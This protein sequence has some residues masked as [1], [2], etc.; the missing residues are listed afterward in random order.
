MAIPTNAAE[1]EALLI[2]ESS[3]SG[4]PGLVVIN[5]DGS[6]LNVS[7]SNIWQYH[8][9]SSSTLTDTTV[10][11]APAA[12]IST[13]ITDISIST[14]AATALNFFLEEGSTKIFGPIYLEAVAGRGFT[15]T[16]STPLKVTAATAVT[17]TTSAA[18]AHSID[19][20]GFTA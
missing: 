8:E 4:Q 14:G 11:A 19:I 12:G 16:F 13:Y 10:K 20:Q 9:D 17:I 5:P 2:K 6:G 7:L 1:K 3:T 15:K 18:I